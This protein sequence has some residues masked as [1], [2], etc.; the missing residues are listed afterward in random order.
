MAKG[1]T[2]C[3]MDSKDADT[4]AI[5]LWYHGKDF[6]MTPKPEN[7]KRFALRG[8]L[9]VK[10]HYTLRRDSSLNCVSSSKAEIQL[11]KDSSTLVEMKI[12]SGVSCYF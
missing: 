4:H 1:K 3:R 8:H 7:Q 11:Y 2:D 10:K 12:Y 5:H 9:G 6:Y